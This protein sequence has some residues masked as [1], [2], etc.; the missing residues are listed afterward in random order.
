MFGEREERTGWR[1]ALPDEPLALGISLV[2]HCSVFLALTTSFQRLPDRRPEA[3]MQVFE[4]SMVP[5][6]GELADMPEVAAPKAVDVNEVVPDPAS[7]RLPSDAPAE[8]EST[9]PEAV[10]ASD[11]SA[12]AEPAPSAGSPDDG[13]SI[14]TPP[15]P[16]PNDA[17]PSMSD[18]EGESARVELPHVELGKGASDAVLL[19]YDQ[20][21]FADAASNAEAARLSGTGRITMSVSVDDKGAVTACTV[22]I[23]S[24]SALLDERACALV[25]S[26]RYRPA[27]DGRGVPHASIVSEV[28][29][30]ARDGMFES[31]VPAGLSGLRRGEDG[32]G[33]STTPSSMPSVSMPPARR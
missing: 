6:D 27:Q 28:L 17:D 14:W 22:A 29:E 13:G 7:L 24:G 9:P 4:V 2:I 5:G 20:G 30:W 26:Y 23:T 1:R 12:S 16:R 8:T 3:T 31:D 10:E 33:P 32:A 21:R 25:S 19:S 15:A 18:V 11:G